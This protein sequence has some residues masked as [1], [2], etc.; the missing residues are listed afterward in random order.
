VRRED[1]RGVL[2]RRELRP[3]LRSGSTAVH[4][5]PD[6]HYL[7]VQDPSGI[8]LFHREPLQPLAYIAARNV[9]PL[10]FSADSQTIV[11]VGIG[12][13]VTRAKLPTVKKVEEKSLPIPDGCL[14]GALSPG[15]EFFACLG[16]D[17]RL[18]VYDIATT[19][20]VFSQPLARANVQSPVVFV[21]LDPDTAFS[22]P[23]GYRLA[24]N[25]GDMVGRD[26]RFSSF[27]YSQDGGTLF[28]S[29]SLES[30]RVEL[31]SGKKTTLPGALRKHDFAAFSALPGERVLAVADAKDVHTAILSL[32]NGEE[33]VAPPVYAE[34]ARM[35]RNPRYL[36]LGDADGLGMRIFD[37]QENRELEAP[38]N[39]SLDIFESEMAV[40]DDRGNLFLYRIGLRGAMASPALDKLAFAVDGSGAV[41][42]V[43][44]GERLYTGP[45]FSSADF[46][47]PSQVYLFAPRGRRNAPRGLD[48]DPWQSY[49]LPPRE[50]EN[51]PRVLDLDLSSG[52]AETAWAD[53]RELLRANGPVLLEYALQ[54][55]LGQRIP[56]LRG[57]MAESDLPYRLRGLDPASGKELW[58]REFPTNPPVPFA[59]PQGD[60][61]VLAWNAKTE[62]TRAIAKRIGPAWEIYSRAQLNKL[63]TFFEVLDARSGATVG[64]VLVQQGSGPY[65]DDAVFSVGDALFLVKDG[66]RVALYSLQSGNSIARLVG[67]MPSASAQSGLF[68]LEE[69]PGRLSIYDSNTG[70]KL[71]QHLFS[72]PILYTHFSADGKR[73]LVLTAYQTAYILDASAVRNSADPQPSAARN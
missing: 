43:A 15:G 52:R 16:P 59:D 46:A 38:S 44:T 18:A 12:L 62:E 65:S 51:A 69:G 55:A 50:Q 68:A 21:P 33:A 39:L 4:Y 35:A 19:Q 17:F 24:N 57:R 8:Y 25:W 2:S 58:K 70:A 5:S 49:L 32:K 64:G 34:S 67:G 42:S 7:M 29:D 45:S 9:Y 37:L 13:I 73:L 54:G 23:F 26:M 63:D 47:D 3:Q 61:L 31:P 30:F 20:A 11:S 27:F 53:G 1:L 6:G 14:Q 48:L 56:A 41:F 40:V 28:V 10:E 72:D 60:R 66:K 36:L 71:G 22:G